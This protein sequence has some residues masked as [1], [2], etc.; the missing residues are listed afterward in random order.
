[1]PVR[2]TPAV[3]AIAIACLAAFFVQQ[4]GDQFFAT[5]LM[6]WFALIPS[7]FVLEHRFWQIFTYSFLH[8]DVM[9]L[10]FNLMMLV[11]IGGELESVWGT[12]R[13]VR[14]YFFCSV[15]AAILYL[16]L[17]FL[18]DRSG[19]LHMP[20][21]GASGAIYGLL[22]AYGLAF[23][24]RVLLFMM[25]F[26]MKAKHFVWILGGIEFMTSIYSGRAGLGSVAHL[27]GMLAG[28]AYLWGRAAIVVA[29]RRKSPG[30]SSKRKSSHL[31]LVINRKGRP[32]QDSEKPKTWH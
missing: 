30:P 1:M 8:G 7:G 29:Q 14:Y 24:E 5:N 23:G 28:L 13:F 4:T 32:S 12:T 6:G 2:L 15:S 10:V 26:P 27:G 18:V 21:V 19:A 22:V 17:Q 9:H 25:L 20:M 16:G 31:K 11:F 3:K